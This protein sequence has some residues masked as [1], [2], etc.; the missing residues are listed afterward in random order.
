MNARRIFDRCRTAGL[1]LCLCVLAFGGPGEMGLCS[2]ARADEVAPESSEKNRSVAASDD[3][4]AGK[5]IGPDRF[6]EVDDA[7]RLLVWLGIASGLGSVVLLVLIVVGARRLR[8]LT[9]STTLKSKY[10]ELEL[11]RAQYRRE[12][13]GLETPPPSNREARR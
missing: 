2:R 13:E 11:L 6:H 5:K 10:D 7:A 9:R 3:K 8:R 1:T 12:M 4:V